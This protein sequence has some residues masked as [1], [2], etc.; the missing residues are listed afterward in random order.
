MLAAS[1][2]GAL[3]L[4]CMMLHCRVRACAAKVRAL[5]RSQQI[6]STAVGTDAGEVVGAS[7]T[8]WVGFGV[9]GLALVCAGS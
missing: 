6:Q 4:Q 5:G 7:T 8:L 3:E 9:G 2:A 1:S